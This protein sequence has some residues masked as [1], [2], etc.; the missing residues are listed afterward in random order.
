MDNSNVQYFNHQ[1]ILIPLTHEEAEEI[2]CEACD[3]LILETGLHGCLSCA[4]YVHR[5]YLHAPQS[6][7]HLSTP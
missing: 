6:V 5:E 2:V 4:Y 7:Q 3:Q 1:H